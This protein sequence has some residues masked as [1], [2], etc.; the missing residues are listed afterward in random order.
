MP[1]KTSLSANKSTIYGI[2]ITTFLWVAYL[3]FFPERS[4]ENLTQIVLTDA[5]IEQEGM[6]PTLTIS[7]E[8]I[9]GDIVLIESGRGYH[10]PPKLWQHLIAADSLSGALRQSDSIHI[11]LTRPESPNVLG[12][13]AGNV[14]LSPEIGVNDLNQIRRWFGY[15]VIFLYAAIA[16]DL[17]RRWLVT[18]IR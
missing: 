3:L 7:G 12:L 11:W 17:L 4:V 16:L 10:F 8:K 6:S 18:F 2:V 15:L 5:K 9:G 14:F 13:R 1:K